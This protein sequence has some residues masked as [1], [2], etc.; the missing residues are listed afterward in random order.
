MNQ[1]YQLNST[2]F[3]GLATKW[4]HYIFEVVYTVVQVVRNGIFTENPI[5]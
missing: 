3:E 5:F 4:L 2:C 1:I